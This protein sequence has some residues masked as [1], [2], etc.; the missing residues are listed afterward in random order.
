M[1]W[2]ETVTEENVSITNLW[3]TILHL[4]TNDIM[5][6]EVTSGMIIVVSRTVG[7]S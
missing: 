5:A 7:I 6:V 4:G 3:S 2:I 1:K